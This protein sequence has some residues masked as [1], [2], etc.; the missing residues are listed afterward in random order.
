MFL[1]ALLHNG[2]FNS[3]LFLVARSGQYA[4]HR[5]GL[6]FACVPC[7]GQSHTIPQFMFENEQTKLAKRPNERPTLRRRWRPLSEVPFS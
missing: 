5:C 7:A 3:C 6:A 2:L 4:N 1:C